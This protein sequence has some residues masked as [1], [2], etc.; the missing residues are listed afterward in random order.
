MVGA[1]GVQE[2]HSVEVKLI[3][4]GGCKVPQDQVNDGVFLAMFAMAGGNVG[5]GKEVEAIVHH[6]FLDGV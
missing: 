2:G 3:C 6:P 4:P 5:G 1:K